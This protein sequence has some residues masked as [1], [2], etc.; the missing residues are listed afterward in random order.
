M[1]IFVVLKVEYVNSEI[2]D[3]T[4][5]EAYSDE[6]DAK[7]YCVFENKF[8]NLESEEYVYEPTELY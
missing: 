6:A 8:I 4:V 5:I 7:A 2:K 1:K 3:K